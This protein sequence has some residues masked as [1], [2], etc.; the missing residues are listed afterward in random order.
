MKSLNWKVFLPPVLLLLAT[1]GFSFSNPEGFLTGAQAVN[2]WILN[3]FGWLF[4]LGALSFLVILAGVYFSPLAKVRI[5]GPNATPLLKRWNWF[6]ITLCTTIATG[7]LFWGTA[8]PLYHLHQPP[9]GLG[10]TPGSA[11]AVP[12]SMSALLLHWTLAPYAMYTVAGLGFAL[13]YYNAGQSFSLGSLVSPLLG[14]RSHKTLGTLIDVVGLYGLVAGMAASLGVGMLTIMGGI[15]SE[16]GIAASPWLLA[17]IALAIVTTFVISASSGLLKGITLLSDL[18]LRAFIALAVFVFIFGPTLSML[19]IGGQGL[20]DFTL[21]L[22]PRTAGLDPRLST[23]WLKSWTL[24]DWANWLAWTP[25]TALFLGRLA[26]GYTVRDFIHFNLL[27]PALFGGIWMIIF[28]GFAL[29]ADVSGGGSLFALLGEKGPESV[30]Y[31]LLHQLPLGK[32]TSGFFLLV[33][34][35][36]YVTAA[37]SNTSAMSGI[38]S[39]GIS[40][41]KPESPMFIKVIWGVLIG[42]VAWVMVNAAGVDGIKMTSVLGG[43]PALFLVLAAAAA[44]VK[45]W[46]KELRRK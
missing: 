25:V 40:P 34:F 23:D 5:G 12:F 30:I 21:N 26:L 10:L 41:E 39:H 15:Q 24:F 38:S 36:S 11:S 33:V 3:R 4:G 43:F 46:W 28:G 7:I 2:A 18:N 27:L 6:A 13:S 42:L 19:K 17:A 29:E 44:V 1:V 9:A 8:E 31:A 22:L 32:I 14:N 35:L 37:D 20:V 16:F 45:L